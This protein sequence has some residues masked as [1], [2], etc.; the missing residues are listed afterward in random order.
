M[1]TYRVKIIIS[2]HGGAYKGW[3][4][5]DN[6]NTVQRELENALLKVFKLSIKT[7]GVSRT[8][9]GVHAL[10]QVVHFDVPDLY[11]ISLLRLM[12]NRHLPRDIF[13]QHIEKVSEK[14]HCRAEN[15][16]K[17]YQYRIYLNRNKLLFPRD[18][19]FE[20]Y[21]YQTL[22]FDAILLQARLLCGTHDFRSFGSASGR[23][24][25]TVKTI[26]NIFV[27]F[28]PE[29]FLI[30][31]V[32]GKSFLYKMV[33]CIAGTLLH[34]GLGKIKCVEEVM[35]GKNRHLAGPNLEAR[36]LC[37][38]KVFYA[39]DDPKLFSPSIPYQNVLDDP[40]L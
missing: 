24:D 27:N 18:R 10:G 11:E 8:D 33:R 21:K 28:K 19:W 13:I 9:A 20:F 15:L 4:I 2:Y 5:Q 35:A 39:P 25:D 37:L 17:H 3:S 34:V 31:D 30:L 32:V 23:E 14:F 7:H 6:A 36:G 22:D 12:L 26:Y 38:M 16:G 40:T 1:N 29:E